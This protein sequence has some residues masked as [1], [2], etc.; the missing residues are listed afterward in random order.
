MESK[1]IFTNKKTLF[2]LA[3]FSCI[4][5]GSAY[6]A[7]K[8]GYTMFN[9][10]TDDIPTKMVFAGYR[11]FLAGVFVLIVSAIMKRK[12][13]AFNIKNVG[14][15]ALYG[16]TYTTIQYTF[17]YI[18]LAYTTGVN[19]SIMN[20]TTTF[21]SVILAHFLYKS[22]RLN[23]NRIMGCIVGFAGVMT[24]N[25][26]TNLLNFSFNFKGDGAV[27]LS[28]FLLAAAS[29]YGKKITQ[30]LD[31]M[32]VTGYQL[33]FG[34]FLL[35]LFGWINHGS[36]TGFNMKSIALLLYLAILSSLAFTLWS[37]LLKYN[38]VG[39]VSVYNFSVPIFGAVLS[40]M[41]L[42]ENIL[43]AKNAVALVFVCLGIWFV[44]REV[45]NE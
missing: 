20:S 11:F 29:I 18:G 33:A 6:P 40:G 35:T 3:T 32:V 14:E 25:L 44:N 15:I 13:F 38:K 41:F 43:Q 7:I 45:E 31:S 12:L 42:N 26:S 17:F 2:L 8:N 23:F 16:L 34:G 22:E 21:F 30:T 1:K 27:I 37:L 28:A 39:V 10:A 9:I 24:V 5:W 4:L 19:G 36:L